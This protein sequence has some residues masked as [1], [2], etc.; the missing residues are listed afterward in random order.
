MGE[1]G[2]GRSHITN[3]ITRHFN[4]IAY[5]QLE[6]VSIKK[7]FLTILQHFV[8]RFAEPI[9]NMVETLTDA[10]LRVYNNVHKTLLPM[11]AKSHYLFNMRDFAKVFQGLCSAYSKTTQQTEDMLRLWVHEN[12]R[13]FGDR[14]INME[15][16]SLLKGLLDEEITKTFKIKLND[17]YTS[18]RVIFGDYMMGL[19]VDPRY[20]APVPDM[21]DFLAKVE[22][23]LEQYNDSVRNPMKLVMFLDACEHVSRISR[24]LRQPQGHALLL[25]VGGS[26][27]QSLSRLGSFIATYKLTNIEVIKGYSMI[28]W[29]E[30]IKKILMVA[31][32]DNKQITFLFVDTQIIN[33]QMLEDIN[34]ILNSGDVPNL[35]KN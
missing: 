16:S 18:E 8:S 27:R 22:D 15:D 30:D 31:G 21:K 26:G 34:N 17:V 32:V 9:R 29:R 35:Y 19:D 3:R 11:P 13:V 33:E 1:P 6:A 24:V 25:G 12:T 28:N 20:Y 23:Y 4:V 10:Q 7:I 14:L 2:G 5:T